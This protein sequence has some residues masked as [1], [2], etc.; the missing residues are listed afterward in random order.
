MRTPASATPMLEPRFI[1]LPDAN[2]AVWERSGPG[3]AV[4]YCHATGFH[5]RCWDRIIELAGAHRSIALD[6]RGHGLSSKPEPP[7]PWRAFGEDVATVARELHLSKAIAVGH[8]MGGHSIALAAALQPDVFAE[9]ILLDP[10][11]LPESGYRGPAAE[12][13]FARKRRNRWQSPEEM[14]ER[15]RPRPPFNTWDERTLLDYCRYGL[16]PAT[17]GD[18][19]VLACPPDIEAA[20]YEHSQMH[21]SNIYPE[22]ARVQTPVTILRA[23]RLFTDGP[24]TDMLASPTAPDLAARFPNARDIVVPYSHFIPMEAPDVVVSEIRAAIQRRG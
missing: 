5:A 22:I 23:P 7:I 11:I 9:L 18:G 6:M 10:V 20:I 1:R 4:L 19:Y 16:F 13:H 8:S 12:P 21:E 15:F 3:P 24:A 14:F 2:I 17:D